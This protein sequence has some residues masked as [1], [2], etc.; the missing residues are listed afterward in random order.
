MSGLTKFNLKDLVKALNTMTKPPP[1]NRSNNENR[2][3]KLEAQKKELNKILAKKINKIS[4][5][6]RK[7]LSPVRRKVSPVRKYYNMYSV[8]A[9]V[10][11]NRAAKAANMR[12]ENLLGRIPPRK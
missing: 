12:H 4:S 8:P 1:R 3:K 6:G 11:L 7:V 5:P 10:I 9:A 2:L